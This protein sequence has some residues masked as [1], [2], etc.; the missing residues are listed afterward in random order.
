MNRIDWNNRTYGPHSFTISGLDIEVTCFYCKRRF[1][2]F[3]AVNYCQGKPHVPHEPYFV[4][5]EE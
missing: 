4:R 2:T 5:E 3:T 1:D